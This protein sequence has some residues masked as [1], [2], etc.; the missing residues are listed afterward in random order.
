MIPTDVYHGVAELD[1]KNVSGLSRREVGLLGEEM[2]ARRLEEIGIEVLERNWRCKEGEA[3]IIAK[4]GRTVVLV[5]VKT[6]VLHGDE[7]L[8]PEVAVDAE[9]RRRYAGIARRYLQTHER[10]SYAR[11]FVVAVQLR[12]GAEPDVH[13]IED[14][15]WG[16]R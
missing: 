6:R 1:V 16:D 3:D 14:A 12:D 4:D 11:F 15:F 13:L 10:Y 8:L 5:E 9:K 2:A 7:W